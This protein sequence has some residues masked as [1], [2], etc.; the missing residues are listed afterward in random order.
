MCGTVVTKCL[1]YL[2]YITLDLGTTGIFAKIVLY[3]NWSL[4]T[5]AVFGLC[6]ASIVIPLCLLKIRPRSHSK[7][8][9][10]KGLSRIA[11]TDKLFHPLILT[12]VYIAI[13]PW[14]LG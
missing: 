13:C 11:A 3:F 1:E 5:Q 12:S 6:A 7:W 14:A 9:L 10:I 8:R 2:G 4:A